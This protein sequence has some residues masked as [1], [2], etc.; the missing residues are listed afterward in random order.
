M[1]NTRKRLGMVIDLDRC[2]GCWTC[3]VVC[4]E[5]NNV[6]LGLWWAR[7]LTVGGDNMDVPEGEYPA[8]RMNYMP[9]HCFHCDNPPC[10]QVCPVGATYKREDGIVMMDFDKCIG[11][12]YCTAAC[13]YTRRYFNWEKPTWP[14]TLKSQLNPDVATRPRGVV[15][16]CTF[17]HHRIRKA[18]AKARSENRELTDADVL[19]LPACARS[20][21]A[22][23]ITFGN[24][25]DRQSEVSRLA[26]SPRAF[27][28]L[29]ELG[30]YP[31]V[32]Y[33]G[34]TKWR[35]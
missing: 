27:R 19:K 25:N 4:K 29:E 11:C 9:I 12:R 28:L 32:I 33:L 31:K 3:A 34:E 5:E 30:T 35:D 14:E 15:E 18:R 16:K 20:C 8:V 26:G 2:I 7:I 22:G 21:P 23:A 13:P 17:C 10:V 1:A 24:L 6:P